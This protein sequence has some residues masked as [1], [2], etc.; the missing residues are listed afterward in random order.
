M[1]VL[2]QLSPAFLFWMLQYYNVRCSGVAEE[3]E[4]ERLQNEIVVIAQSEW[5]ITSHCNN[6]WENSA[7]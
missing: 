3:R 6:G 1:C 4:A 5:K 2:I 7:T